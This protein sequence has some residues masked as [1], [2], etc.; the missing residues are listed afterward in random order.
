MFVASVAGL[1]LGAAAGP[2]P[3]QLVVPG[4]SLGGLHLGADPATALPPLGPPA[5]SDG[6]TLKAW[7]TW[8]GHGQPPAQLDV[9][10]AVPPGGDGARQAVQ[11]VRATSPYFC[12]ANGLRSGST[13]TQIR[14][15]YG[16]LP[17]VATYRLAAGPRYLYDDA[18]RGIAF[19]MDGSA[20]SSHCRALVVHVP[21]TSFLSLR[22]YLKDMPRQR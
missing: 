20:A 12:L 19:E 6:A 3:G 7:A 8:Y 1:L 15:A 13:L 10:T 11:A 21:G 4:R 2:T 5:F 18:R 16:R 17:L 22:P 14:A 9:F